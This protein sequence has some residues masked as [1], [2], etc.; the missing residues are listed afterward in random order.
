MENL[1]KAV[2][3]LEIIGDQP[4]ED[5]NEFYNE[6]VHR[7]GNGFCVIEPFVTSIE[8]KRCDAPK[9]NEEEK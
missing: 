6:F 7:F 2:V 5:F 8:I 1:F 4:Y 3:T 9:E